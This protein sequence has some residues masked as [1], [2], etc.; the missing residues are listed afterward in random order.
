MVVVATTTTVMV[1]REREEQAC[2]AQLA[3]RAD[4]VS[5]SRNAS[6]RSHSYSSRRLR[7]DKH[8]CKAA[9]RMTARQPDSLPP[10]RIEF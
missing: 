2:D 3:M 8:G 10:Q 1:C 6:F 9:G 5:G 4:T 7:T